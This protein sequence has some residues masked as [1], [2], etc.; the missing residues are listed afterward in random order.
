MSVRAFLGI[1]LAPHVRTTLGM[2][3]AALRAES[4]P[5]R[6]EKWVPE[7]NLHVTLKFLGTVEESNIDGIIEAVTAA[8]AEYA[9]YPLALREL[10]AIPRLRAAQMIWATLAEGET[11]TAA[12]ADSIDRQLEP[13]GFEVPARPFTAHITLARAHRPKAIAFDAIDA[14]NRILYVATDREK[15][16]S[17]RGITL[18]SSTL[19]PRGALYEE[20]A[21]VPLMGD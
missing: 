16:M 14:G 7:E 20:L 17:V 21:I 2:S 3:A 11:V 4:R 5:W 12:L 8:A 6:G 15:R 1:G 18:Y 19:T 13:L 9:E 10:H